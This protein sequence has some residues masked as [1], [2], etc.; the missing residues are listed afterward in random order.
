M[1]LFFAIFVRT[2]NFFKWKH[3]E[4]PSFFIMLEKMSSVY[5]M[6]QNTIFD[7]Y[8]WSTRKFKKKLFLELYLPM[9]SSR[10][11]DKIIVQS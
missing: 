6:L 2:L 1:V 3:I 10:R 4:I 8:V 11:D 7:Q 9:L 5:K